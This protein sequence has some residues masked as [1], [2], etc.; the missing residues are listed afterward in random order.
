VLCDFG[1]SGLPPF[2]YL[3]SMIPV[4]CPRL[5]SIASSP[6]HGEDR[7]ELLVVLNEWEDSE[8]RNRKGLATQFLFNAKPNIKVA[9]QIRRGIL[10]PPENSASPI[11][12]F[13]LGT[14][15]WRSISLPTCT[16]IQNL[17]CLLYFHQGVAPFRGFLQHRQALLRSGVALGPASL[18]VGF[19]HEHHDFY[20]KDEF[21]AWLK[22]GVL[23]SVHA[24]FSHDN[25]SR[26]GGKLYF[27]SDMI[28]EKPQDMAKA[29]QLKAELKSEVIKKPRI[30]VYYC[31]PAMG[32]PEVS[33]SLVSTYPCLNCL[34]Y[35][36]G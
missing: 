1:A 18:Y 2:E 34:T 22:E 13:G 28:E 26:R 11:L 20:L 32:I 35:S 4:I 31:G 30:H 7:L 16:I 24:A 29:L 17:R 27:I 10:Q 5:Y 3:L 9:V 36:T 15:R 14:V 25:I 8:N 6:L 23:T 33:R 19:R 12:M 21:E